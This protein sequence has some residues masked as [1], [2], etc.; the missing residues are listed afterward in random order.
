M[1]FEL[2]GFWCAA[3]VTIASTWQSAAEPSPRAGL[4]APA[5]DSVAIRARLPP[6]FLAE[7][8]AEWVSVLDKAQASKDFAGVHCLLGKWRYLAYA[9]L[10]DRVRMAGCSPCCVSCRLWSGTLMRPV[11]MAPCPIAIGLDMMDAG[12]D[13]GWLA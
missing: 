1:L 5:A 2:G 11:E 6:Q 7:F 10:R 8:N 3:P 12:T 9:E 4:V 13:R